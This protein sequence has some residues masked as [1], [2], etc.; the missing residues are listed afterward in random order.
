MNHSFRKIF[1]M[2]FCAAGLA[3]LTINGVSQVP[4]VP[5]IHL[6]NRSNQYIYEV[7]STNIIFIT[8]FKGSND[9]TITRLAGHVGADFVDAFGSS[10]SHGNPD[11]LTNFV[12]SPTNGTGDDIPGDI[13]CIQTDAGNLLSLQF[14]FALGLTVVDRLLLIDCDNSEQY[15][16]Q[17]YVKNGSTY[18]AVSLN[19]WGVQNYE[20]STQDP[21][22]GGFPSWSAS[23]GLLTSSGEVLN[24]PLTIFTP[25][26]TIDRVVITQTA[27]TG[28]ADIQFVH[29]AQVNLGSLVISRQT[30]NV[31][32]KIPGGIVVP[33]LETTTN[34][35]N[36]VWT[37]LVTNG[38]PGTIAIPI[39]TNRQQ[40]FRL[41]H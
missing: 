26:Q 11:Y 16:I 6:V 18:N 30:T 27:S 38:T 24:E 20:G 5:V 9:V 13:N 10:Y 15:R 33:V 17:A 40:F 3:V 37:T 41:R 35:I 4:S 12:G 25:N 39:S 31:L 7:M 29:A 28:T 8:D 22:L 21:N 32:I 34:L 36:G 2:L 19:G 1:S 23:S 14:D